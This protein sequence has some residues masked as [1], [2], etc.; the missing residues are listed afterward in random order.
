VPESL[1]QH[2]DPAVRRQSIVQLGQWDKNGEAIARLSQALA[3]PSAEVRQ[4]A[5]FVLAQS[6]PGSENAKA[7]ILTIVKNDSESK[8]IRLSAL[9]ALDSFSLTEEERAA[10]APLRMLLIDY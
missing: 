9:Q 1:S 6:N 10:V 3:D 5:I 8:Q 2:S 4:A 7:A